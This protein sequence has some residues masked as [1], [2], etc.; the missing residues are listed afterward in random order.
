MFL[1]YQIDYLLWLQNLRNISYDFFTPFF[2]AVTQFGEDLILLLFISFIYWCLDKK[3]GEFIILNFAFGY[4]A[5]QFLKMMF[6]INRP[7]ILSDKIKPVPDALPEAHGYSFPSG[8]TSRAMAIW[9]SLALILWDKKIVRYS[10][11]LLIILIMFSR[12]Y[13]GVHTP[14]DVLVSFVVGFI[15]L[16]II[17]KVFSAMDKN[18]NIENNI[19]IAGIALCI[20][21][22][23]AV[24][25]KPSPITINELVIKAGSQLPSFYENMGS[26]IGLF[27]GWFTCKKFIPY[28]TNISWIKRILRYLIGTMGLL[29]L[30]NLSHATF[31]ND[32]GNING[33]FIYT[34]VISIYITLFYPWIFTKLEKFFDI[35]RLIELWRKD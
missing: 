18:K 32:F 14:Q 21:T 35:D 15:L 8:H 28:E 5:N 30:I 3:V 34:F 6:C 20:L 25:I 22:I 10:L 31:I 17:K 2:L 11:I 33:N 24:I 27:I 19:F 9:G 12:N 26:I 29:L 1:N 23:L 16:L 4:L 7:W 13:L